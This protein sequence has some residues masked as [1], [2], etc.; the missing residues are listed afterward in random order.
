MTDNI[1]LK[2]ILAFMITSV[3]YGLIAG[4][5]STF[6]GSSSTSFAYILY[7]ITYYILIILFGEIG[8]K[9]MKLVVIDE[10]SNEVTGIKALLSSTIAHLITINIVLSFLIKVSGVF[11]IFAIIPTIYLILFLFG[12]DVWHTSLGTKVVY[13]K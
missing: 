11:Q 5:I 7:L 12:K 2:R 4:L 13:K 3:I 6:V 9:V 1:T 10:N 8:K